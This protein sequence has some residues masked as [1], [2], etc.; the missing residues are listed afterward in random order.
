MSLNFSSAVLCDYVRKEE[1]GKYILIGV[2]TGNILLSEFHKEI[3]LSAFLQGSL[4]E[5]KKDNQVSFRYQLDKKEVALLGGTISNPKDNSE[6]TFNIPP[7][8]VRPEGPCALK[9]SYKVKGGRWK[10]LLQKDFALIP[11][12]V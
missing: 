8:V 7:V 1:N 6:V 3:A 5:P 4:T 9:L 10:Q 11:K 2:Y 12:Q